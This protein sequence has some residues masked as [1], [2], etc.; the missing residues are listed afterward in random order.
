MDILEKIDSG[1]YTSPY[2]KRPVKPEVLRKRVSEL[3][4]DEAECVANALSDY[5]AKM[6]AYKSAAM[7]SSR[8]QQ[9]LHAEFKRD[10]LEYV[11]LLDHPKAAA[12]A[13]FA[14]SE[15]HS[16]SYTEVIMFLNDLSRLF[17]D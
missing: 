11:G 2:I 12:I 6:L 7:E 3:T 9:E 1:Y 8:R 4:A 10:A 14:W 17:K 16:S 15:K 5:N 13:D